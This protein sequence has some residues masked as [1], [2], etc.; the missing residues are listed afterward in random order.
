MEKIVKFDFKRG[1]KL[2]E[3][4]KDSNYE[5]G[6]EYTLDPPVVFAGDALTFLNNMD[7]G[8]RTELT[9]RRARYLEVDEAGESYIFIGYSEEEGQEKKYVFGFSLLDRKPDRVYPAQKE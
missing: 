7:G 4:P 6:V 2:K 9:F 8:K 3:E 5:E 1:E